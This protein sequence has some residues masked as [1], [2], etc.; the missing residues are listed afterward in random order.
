MLNVNMYDTLS[1]DICEKIVIPLSEYL[2]IFM[3][4]PI[5]ML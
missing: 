2:R 3:V 4:F 5:I 1:C